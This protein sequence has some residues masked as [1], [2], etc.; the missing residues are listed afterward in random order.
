[1][2]SFINWLSNLHLSEKYKGDDIKISVLIPA[3][4]EEKNLTLLLDDLSQQDYQNFEVL[5]YD[6]HSTDKTPEIIESFAQKDSRFGLLPPQELPSGWLGKTFACDQLGRAAKGEYLLF[7]DSDVRA[8]SDLLRKAL[9][10]IRKHKLALLSVFPHQIMKSTGERLTVPLMNWILVSLLPMILIRKSKK[11]SLSAANGQF[12]F[13]D[14]EIYRQHF[15]HEQVRDNLVEDIEICRKMKSE[16]YL[17]ATLLGKSDIECRMYTNYTEG[18]NGFAK[19]VVEF[20]GGSAFVTFFYG[21]ITIF[22]ILFI[23]L[24][25]GWQ[26]L[27]VFSGMVILN[28]LFVSFSGKQPVFSN[29]FL[30]VPQMI[31]FVII[32]FKG[33]RV[34]LTGKYTWKGRETGG[35]KR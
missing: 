33:I 11:P 35:K 20:F 32:I 6:D 29:L 34:K 13:F 18:L 25:W 15:W 28:R 23:F 30:H 21:L 12:M 7:L 9:F 2:V 3:R 5:V 16:G 8:S 4:N 1:M 24:N 31:T 19:N 14:Q 17:V 27:L 26:M 22:G 10:Y